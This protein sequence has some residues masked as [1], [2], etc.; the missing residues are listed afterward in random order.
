[1]YIYVYTINSYIVTYILPINLK[2]TFKAYAIKERKSGIIL[3]A[4]TTLRKCIKKYFV[5]RLYN[6]RKRE[7][8]R[9]HEE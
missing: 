8:E 3:V 7:R 6:A 1:M 5:Y 4:D 2:F 9:L